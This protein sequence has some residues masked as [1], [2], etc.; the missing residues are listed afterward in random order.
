MG[1]SDELIRRLKGSG[2][3]D[4]LTADMRQLI[5][6]MGDQLAG[7]LMARLDA[8][9]TDLAA[10]LDALSDPGTAEGRRVG[11][12]MAHQGV[13]NLVEVFGGGLIVCGPGSSPELTPLGHSLANFFKAA[14]DT[15]FSLFETLAQ[16]GQVT[17]PCAVFI[18]R[19]RSADWQE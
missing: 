18:K 4:T 7:A 13:L 11:T 14:A 15:G 9:E 10:K 1:Y 12:G 6:S 16:L 2:K 3:W 19:N 8:E 17:L 5:E